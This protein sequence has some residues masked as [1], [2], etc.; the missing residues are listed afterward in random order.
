MSEYQYLKYLQHI[1]DYIAPIAANCMEAIFHYAP[2]FYPSIAS[3]GVFL[4]VAFLGGRNS[5]GLISVLSKEPSSISKTR[6]MLTRIVKIEKPIRYSLIHVM[7]CSVLLSLQFT[8]VIFYFYR[9]AKLPNINWYAGAGIAVLAAFEVWQVLRGWRLFLYAIILLAVNIFYLVIVK[10]TIHFPWGLLE[11]YNLWV[12]AGIII[13]FSII[14][15][16][17]LLQRHLRNIQRYL[18]IYHARLLLKLDKPE[19]AEKILEQVASNKLTKSQ[20]VLLK[21]CKDT[22]VHKILIEQFSKIGDWYTIE[23]IVDTLDT[24]RAVKLL[25]DLE[26][27]KERDNLLLARLVSWKKRKALP[28]VMDLMSGYPL[29]VAISLLDKAISEEE[30]LLFLIALLAN[31]N[32][33]S[34]IREMLNGLPADKKLLLVQDLPDSNNR[35]LLLIELLLE[36]DKKHEAFD[37]LKKLDSSFLKELLPILE[38]IQD[39]RYK[40]TMLGW[41]YGQ[42]GEPEKAVEF[43]ELAFIENDFDADLLLIL[44]NAYENIGQ[45]IKAISVLEVML[46]KNIDIEKTL[47]R[48]CHLAIRAEVM[49]TPLL[50]VKEEKLE[51]LASE[52]LITLAKY[53]QHF[54]LIDDAKRIAALAIKVWQEADAALLLGELLENEGDLRGAADAYAKAG[55]EGVLR[56]GLCLFKLEDFA[57]ATK[58]L[59]GVKADHKNRAVV[60]YHLAYAAFRAN[61]F[62]DA[63]DA[64]MKLD[65]KQ[66][67][68]VIQGDLAICFAHEAAILKKQGDYQQAREYFE[69]AL[70]RMPDEKV[71]EKKQI[72]EGLADTLYQLAFAKMATSKANTGEIESILEHLRELIGRKWP[73]L[74]F[75]K[76]LLLLKRNDIEK[77]LQKFSLLCRRNPGSRRYAFHRLLALVMAGNPDHAN[78]ALKEFLDGNDDT[79]GIRAKMLLAVLA[80]KSGN[81]TVAEQE[82]RGTIG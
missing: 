52:T 65:P 7:F 41:V 32:K 28:E 29:D 8:P 23:K 13:F 56:Q 49:S 15:Y 67:D 38:Q 6:S 37:Q 14:F 42:S 70:N 47:L 39:I 20:L 60:L 62:S 24:D 40:N 22:R 81:W 57:A 61:M 80:M 73:E 17:F 66:Q 48:L 82:L 9:L 78:R 75:L 45:F 53:F 10:V 36:Q 33:L 74:D 25:S 19:E 1:K 18:W 11:S 59:K 27:S 44:A 63:I 31:H 54:N 64:F 79:Y 35:T 21:E 77:A 4:I 16:F 55:K 5:D 2:F 46:A 69:Q 76:G 34:R 68:S 72:Q 26:Q 12:H 51:E 30:Q 3:F 43:L 71:A 58:I 50:E